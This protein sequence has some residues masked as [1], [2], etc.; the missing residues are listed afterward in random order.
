VLNTIVT[1][2][3]IPHYGIA[4][5]GFFLL[6]EDG[7]IVDKLFNRHFANREGVEA[8]LD[9]F[10][11][12]VAIGDR[13]PDGS[14]T[15]DDG[16]EISVFMRG[17]GG[18]LRVGPMRR[19]VVRF[20]MPE[21]LHIYDEPVPEGMVATRVEITGPDGL[22]FDPVES[23][24]TRPFSLPGITERLQVWDGTVD[25]VVPFFANSGMAGALLSG[26][27]S[28][29]LE[30]SVSYQACDDTRCFLPRTHTITLDVPLEFGVVPGFGKLKSFSPN[31]IDMDSAAHM[32]RLFLRKAAESEST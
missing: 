25:F 31:V 20:E 13:K 4:F 18:V 19:V 27:G 14:V 6:D 23:P 16:I 15:E 11:G 26:D 24:A 7:V 17:G 1:P 5:P 21:G 12:R 22:R 2:A 10:G 29:T 3:D 28:I 30:V 9:S 32:Q 8:I